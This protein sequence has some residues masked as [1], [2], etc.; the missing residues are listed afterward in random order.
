[1]FKNTTLPFSFYW[2]CFIV[3]AINL[4]RA[5]HST[6]IIYGRNSKMK[7]L[8]TKIF[9]SKMVCVLKP[10]ALYKWIW[11]IYTMRWLLWNFT[12]IPLYPFCYYTVCWDITSLLGKDNYF[13]QTIHFWGILSV[14]F[15]VRYGFIHRH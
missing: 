3:W 4:Y 14:I 11:D 10:E 7:N 2:F 6:G 12:G 13:I 5:F 15:F 8:L 9:E 1:M